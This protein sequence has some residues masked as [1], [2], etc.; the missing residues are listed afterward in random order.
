MQRSRLEVFSILV[1]TRRSV[2]HLFLVT[3]SHMLDVL[4]GDSQRADEDYVATYGSS[5]S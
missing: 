2:I 1:Q 5:Y 4:R 3:A